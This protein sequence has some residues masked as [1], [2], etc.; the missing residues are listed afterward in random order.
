MNFSIL[1]DSRLLKVGLFS[2]VLGVGAVTMTAANAFA[3]SVSIDDSLT[4]FTVVSQGQLHAPNTGDGINERYVGGFDFNGHPD[5][6]TFSDLIV[7]DEYH[8]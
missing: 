3:D 2:V 1:S 5:W 4:S 6:V 7:L 8:L